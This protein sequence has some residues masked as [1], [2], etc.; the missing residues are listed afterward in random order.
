MCGVDAQQLLSDA[1]EGVARDVQRE[2]AGRTDASVVAEPDQRGCEQQVPDD[3]VEECG[4]EGGV[5]RVAG[6][7]VCG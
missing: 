1:A 2:Q 7:A 6:G 4:V 3:L 5:L